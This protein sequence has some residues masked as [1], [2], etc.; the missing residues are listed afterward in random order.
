V[1]EEEQRGREAE[2]L[3]ARRE[4]RER[5]GDRAYALNL[6]RA[7][8]STTPTPSDEVRSRFGMLPADH[9]TEERVTVAGRVVL[10]RS[11][12]KLV[13]LVLRDR[14]GDVQVVCDGRRLGEGAGIVEEIDL[15][16]VVA[17]SGPVGTTRKGEL[18]IF[19]ETV[20]ML[21]KALRPLPEKWHGLRICSSAFGTCTWRRTSTPGGS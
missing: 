17:A 9:V 1:T 10:R 3:K 7:I 8:G 16:D 6:E 13:F 5:L 14:A 2:V 19:A 12:G 21:S 15:G 20:A 18:S 4:S 11:F